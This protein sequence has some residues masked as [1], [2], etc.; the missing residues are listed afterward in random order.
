MFPLSL[1]ALIQ[2][3]HVQ[4]T[5]NILHTRDAEAVAFASPSVDA[6]RGLI[7][8]LWRCSGVTDP[9][10]LLSRSTVQYFKQIKLAAGDMAVQNDR[11]VVLLLNEEDEEVQEFAQLFTS[12]R[13]EIRGLVDDAEVA[14]SLFQLCLVQY[15]TPVGKIN[16]HKRHRHAGDLKKA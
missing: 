15:F 14:S 5:G 4:E 1:R 2:Y 16:L 11:I 12:L 13:I 3:L 6:V 8:D 10:S 7:I 9:E